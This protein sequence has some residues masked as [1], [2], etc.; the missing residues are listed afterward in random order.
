MTQMGNSSS[1]DRRINLNVYGKAEY[2]TELLRSKK[3]K[4]NFE[5]YLQIFA[6]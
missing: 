2:W 1:W 4:N 5:T 6:I 3:N